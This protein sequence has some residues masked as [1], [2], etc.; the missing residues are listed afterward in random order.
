M[1]VWHEHTLKQN[2]RRKVNEKMNLYMSESDKIK[3][4]PHLKQ[5]KNYMHVL[6]CSNRDR[7]SF[8]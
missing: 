1:L 5:I 3:K 4:E 8:I 2:Y 7:I 6:A